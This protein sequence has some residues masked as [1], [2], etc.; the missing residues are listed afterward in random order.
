MNRTKIECE[1]IKW[2][3]IAGFFDGEGS[4][5]ILTIKRKREGVFRFR[6][7]VKIS[8]KSIELL[9]ILREMLGFGTVVKTHGTPC[10]QINGSAKLQSFIKL[11]G[12]YCILKQKQLLLLE[13]LLKLQHHKNTRY[14]KEEMVE[15]I[16][17]R[18]EVHRLNAQ[19]RDNITLKYPM[20]DCL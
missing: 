18:D 4:A 5:M 16:K 8:Q 10:L 14:S 2:S 13:N 20:E 9:E 11:I 7:V 6:A 17:L 1:Q 3:Y 15:M 12:P 19:N